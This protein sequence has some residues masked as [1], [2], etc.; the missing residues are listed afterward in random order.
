MTRGEIWWADLA[1]PVGSA[2]GYR[3]PVAIVS[4]DLFN[5]SPIRTIVV[6]VLTS[7]LRLA[8]A[9]GNVLVRAEETGLTKDSVV[10]ASQILTVD[11]GCLTDRIGSLP[12]KKLARVDNGLREVLDL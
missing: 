7:N 6:A 9:P 1:D 2:P 10:N 5:A 4:S 3:R 11:R 8:D 12:L